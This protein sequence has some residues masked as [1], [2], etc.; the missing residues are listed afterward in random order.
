MKQKELTIDIY[1]DFKLKNPLVYTK[2]VQY[3]KVFFGEMSV[4]I[5]HHLKLELLMHFQL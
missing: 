1:A 5:F 2:L 3:F 4:S